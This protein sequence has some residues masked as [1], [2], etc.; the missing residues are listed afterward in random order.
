MTDLKLKVGL[1]R[2]EH[3]EALFDGR[4]NWSVPAFVDSRLSREFVNISES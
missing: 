1:Y 3:T 2:Y 4:V